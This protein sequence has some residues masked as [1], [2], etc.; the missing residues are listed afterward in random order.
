MHI[1]NYYETKIQSSF[2][3]ILKVKLQTS[4]DNDDFFKHSYSPE[5]KTNP[6]TIKSSLKSSQSN[7][8][9]LCSSDIHTLIYI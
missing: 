4:N 1:K 7:R 2:T 6:L 3:S 5:M 8:A 9:I